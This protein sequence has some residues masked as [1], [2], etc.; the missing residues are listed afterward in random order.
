MLN[1]EPNRSLYEFN[2]IQSKAIKPLKGK[3]NR[4]FI[5]HI[6]AGIALNYM[7]KYISQPYKVVLGP[8]WIQQLEWV[9]WDG[10]IIKRD[11]QEILERYYLPKDFVA[12]FEFKTRGIYG[13]KEKK[14]KQKTVGEVI[15]D[16]RQNF[17][18][19]QVLCPNLRR[20][21]YV[22]LHE[23]KPMRRTSIDYFGETKKLEPE[24]VTCILF[25]AY[26]IE[27]GSQPVQ[28]PNE[29]KRLI[30]ELQQL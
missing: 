16:I 18:S 25:D 19:A 9:Q 11:A 15:E 23:R 5:G 27:R 30:T 3:S 6:F 12:L 4:A 29:W 14:D 8:L 28:Y 26:S 17:H 13:R 22:T 7:A 24:I 2:S 10:A 1:Q 21:F 20:C